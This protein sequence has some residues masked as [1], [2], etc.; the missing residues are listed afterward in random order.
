MSIK[1]DIFSMITEGPTLH[2]I[3]KQNIIS[4]Y[5]SNIKGPHEDCLTFEKILNEK[6]PEENMKEEMKEEMN[7][8]NIL[9]YVTFGLILLA[10]LVFIY[11]KII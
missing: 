8:N 9:C 6:K 11:C 1:P 2:N 3:L 7:G 5:C 10:L 4:T